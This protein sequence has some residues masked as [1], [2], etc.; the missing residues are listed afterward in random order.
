MTESAWLWVPSKQAYRRFKLITSRQQQV[1]SHHLESE[2]DFEISKVTTELLEENLMDNDNTLK[3][4][5]I[6]DKF[7]VILQMRIRSVGS[8]IELQHDEIN[9]EKFIE[10][11]ATFVD[12]DFVYEFTHGKNTYVCGLPTIENELEMFALMKSTDSKQEKLA[13]QINENVSW[14]YLKEINKAP[15]CQFKNLNERTKVL[16]ALPSAVTSHIKT[17]FIERVNKSIKYNNFLTIP[18]DDLKLDYDLETSFYIMQFILKYPMSAI[19]EQYHV[20]I[21]HGYS[22]EFIDNCLAG[23]RLLYLDIIHKQRE[24]EL[25]GLDNQNNDGLSLLNG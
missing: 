24:E 14:G 8:I 25:K 22:G 19:R 9:L 23:D 10:N 6:M 13:K 2:D 12:N 18:S 15:L 20:L 3:Q 11:V 21:Q 16:K 1:L 4:W 17:N 5:T 7:F